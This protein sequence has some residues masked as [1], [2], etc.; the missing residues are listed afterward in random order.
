MRTGARGREGQGQINSDR[1][2]I[3]VFGDA[4][5]S[6]RRGHETQ[7][8][9]SCSHDYQRPHVCHRP[10]LQEPRGRSLSLY[11]NR[12]TSKFTTDRSHL[13]NDFGCNFQ[14]RHNRGSLRP[15]SPPRGVGDRSAAVRHPVGGSLAI[16]TVHLRLQCPSYCFRVVLLKSQ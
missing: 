11:C 8:Q 1:R 4:T 12:N 10:R 7:E 16:A 13:K 3:G 14:T 6:Q 9:H 2:Q 5:C 15:G